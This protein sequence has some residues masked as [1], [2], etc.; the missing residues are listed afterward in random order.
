MFILLKSIV[1]DE[2]VRGID[3][4]KIEDE[5][6]EDDVDDI[7]YI[8]GN[9]ADKQSSHNTCQ[10]ALLNDTTAR[11]KHAWPWLISSSIGMGIC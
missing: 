11:H 9:S 2:H 10:P 6:H 7:F 1:I 5:K 8:E 4:S 3:I